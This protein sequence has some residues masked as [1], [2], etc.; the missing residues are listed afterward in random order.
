MKFH[1]TAESDS[2]TC[3][4]PYQFEDCFLTGTE[5]TRWLQVLREGAKNPKGPIACFILFR[6]RFGVRNWN[7]IPSRRRFVHAFHE[8]VLLG[9]PGA[10]LQPRSLCKLAVR[11]TIVSPM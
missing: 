10:V 7:S 2:S 11:A 6:T 1:S 5:A 3:L 9:L 4:E 8:C